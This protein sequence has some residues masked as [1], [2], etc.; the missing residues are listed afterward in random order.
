LQTAKD[1]LTALFEQLQL[2]EQ[3]HQQ[4]QLEQLKEQGSQHPLEVL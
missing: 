2:S 3:Q 1:Q 4:T